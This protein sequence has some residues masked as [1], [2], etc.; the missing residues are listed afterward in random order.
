MDLFGDMHR[1][2]AV[3][4]NYLK[5]KSCE[6]PTNHRPRVH[7]QTKYGLGRIKRVV[8][9]LFVLKAI[10]HRDQPMHLF[11]GAALKLVSLA[12]VSLSVA[13]IAAVASGP[14]WIIGAAIGLGL[15]AGLVALQMTCFGLLAELLVSRQNTH[16]AASKTQTSYRVKKVL[17]QGLPKPPTVAKSTNRRA[18]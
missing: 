18:A 8:L 7:G 17:G 1:F 15:L 14:L 12:V 6:V 2:I 10:Q 9:D 5:A 11:G 3:L 4:A 16:A 13:G